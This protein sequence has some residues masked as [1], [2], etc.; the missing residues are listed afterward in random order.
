M[1]IFSPPKGI[2]QIHGSG[3]VG[4]FAEGPCSEEGEGERD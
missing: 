3:V 4:A 1:G 2:P